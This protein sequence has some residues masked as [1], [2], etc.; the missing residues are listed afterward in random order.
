[1]PSVVTLWLVSVVFFSSRLS[2][3][4]IT[5]SRIVRAAKPCESRE[6]LLAFDHVAHRLGLSIPVRILQ[7][8][9]TQVPTVVGW[10]RPV[11]L[12]PIGCFSGM[13]P[14]QIEAILAHEIAHILRR[15]YFF[16]VLQSVLEALFFYHPAVWWL[17]KII[18][19]E[20]EHCC[21]DLAVECTGNAL[22]YARALSLLEEHR[23]TLPVI[24]LGANGGILFM[25]IK[26]ILG[27]SKK[28][29][30]PQTMGLFILCLAVV[31]LATYVTTTG[32]VQ[33]K[34]LQGA[35]SVSQPTDATVKFAG[36]WH[37]MCNGKSV[38][39]M[40]LRP[41]GTGFTGSVSA[42]EGIQLDKDGTVLN[43][44]PGAGTTPLSQSSLDG[45]VLRFKIKDEDET[46]WTMTL[47]EDGTARLQGKVP[48]GEGPAMKPIEAKKAR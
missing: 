43:I 13:S 6:L 22:L 41:S 21:D 19:V 35:Q 30:P 23:G 47:K 32:R 8:G 17:S 31:F 2:Y 16:S 42:I 9:I 34:E 36:T 48:E 7:C 45:A 18:R 26:R 12:I 40:I 33:A 5:V 1:M 28:T 27:E 4:L 46:E 14:M 11:I 37:W 39:T 25:R 3:G 38:V 44:E 24:A 10:I 15:D 20:R 29:T